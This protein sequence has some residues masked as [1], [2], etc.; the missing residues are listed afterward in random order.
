MRISDWSSDVCSSDLRRC[1]RAATNF[2]NDRNSANATISTC[3]RRAELRNP[4]FSSSVRA[5]RVEAPSFVK[6]GPCTSSGR[7]VQKY[8]ELIVDHLHYSDG[9]LNDEDITLQRLAVKIGTPVDAYS[10]AKLK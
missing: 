5:E 8:Q 1:P 3:P 9:G 6:N 4:S 7:T 2:S 10:S